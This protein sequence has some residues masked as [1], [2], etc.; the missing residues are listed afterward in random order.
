M[1]KSLKSIFQHPQSLVVCLGF[2][3]LGLLMSTWATRLPDLKKILDISDGQV[4]TSLLILS[5]GALIISP[6]SSYIM[7]HF[8]TGKATLAS[9]LIQS[10][11][12]ILPFLVTSFPGFLLAMFL[13]GL[14]NGFLNITLNASA[15]I[16]EKKY[17]RLIMSGSHGMF[18]IGA[19]LGA[20]SSG[21]IASF[22]VDPKIHMAG[23]IFFIY[24]INFTLRKT[25]YSV[26]NTDIKSPVFAIPN[27][28]VLG[29][30]AITFCIVLAELTI[31]DWSAVYLKDSL[32]SSAAMAGLGFAGFSFTMAIGRLSG[33]RIV[34]KFGKR[35]IIVFGCIFSSIGLSL[36][37]ITH[38]PFVAILGFTLC[39]VGM[40]VIVPMLYSL[41]ANQQGISPGVGI[42]SI[43]TACVFAGLVGRPLVGLVSDYA[44]MA[45]SV[46]I[47]AGFA[48]A[49]SIIGLGL[50]V[51]TKPAAAIRKA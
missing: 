9:V 27:M 45:T 7:D 6:F 35:N 26:P 11:T 33:D 39:G 20:T 1:F 50:A 16:V 38:L 47:A 19:I 17:R 4:G 28:E 32:K 24:L 12:Y 29:F 30:T 40:A 43:A 31:M 22:D 10:A 36:A 37:A 18:S 48:L 49:A 51:G 14:S 5:I 44:G 2:A 21:I 15:A 13:I 34:P 25:W 46:W 42:A 41:S 23:L 3:S 8:P